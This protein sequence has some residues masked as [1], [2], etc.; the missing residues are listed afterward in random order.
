MAWATVDSNG[1]V[2]NRVLV[3]P[4][5]NKNGLVEINDWVDIGQHFETPYPHEKIRKEE[6]LA[7]ISIFQSLIT[8]RMRDE[9]LMGSNLTGLGD[10]GSMTAAEYIAYIYERIQ[11]LRSQL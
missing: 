5:T 1:I 2:T 8:P 7:E 10:D 4:N 11:D 9:A 6:I 3:G